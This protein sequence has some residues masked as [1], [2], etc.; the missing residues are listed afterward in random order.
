[1]TDP[2]ELCERDEAEVML[3]L[4]DQVR[5]F[6]S[7]LAFQ[8]EAANPLAGR[9]LRDALLILAGRVHEIG[10]VFERGYLSHLD[11]EESEHELRSE[12]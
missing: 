12:N 9:E 2:T 8:A 6:A 1:M 4:L 7:N 11:E 5:T 10:H 3:V